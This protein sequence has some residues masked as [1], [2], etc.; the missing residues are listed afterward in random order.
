LVTIK[1]PNKLIKTDKG[2]TLVYREEDI[3]KVEKEFD[4]RGN[5]IRVLEKVIEAV[6]AQPNVIKRKPK[7]KSKR[8]IRRVT[9]K[10]KAVHPRRFA[11]VGKKLSID[12]L[13]K[14]NRRV[15]E[16][17]LHCSATRVTSNVSAKA[18]HSMHKRRG[19]SG[20]G[21]H[22]YVRKDGTVEAGRTVDYI[23][24]HVHNHNTGTIGV[25]YEGG[26]DKNGI[27]MRN[28][29]S[30][31]QRRVVIKLLRRLKDMYNATVTG[32]REHYQVHKACPATDMNKIRSEL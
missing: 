4:G 22:Y 21:Y 12:R 2:N 5:Y 3:E 8:K 6:E 19:W 27:I 10:H 25:C 13:R 26:L 30:G 32:H 29:L 14:T 7:T 23:G 28:G 1:V 18:V 17:V 11:N 16:I 31:K 9:K 20:I 24:A 15:N